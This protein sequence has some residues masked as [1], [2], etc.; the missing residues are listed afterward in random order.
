MAQHISPEDEIN[1]LRERVEMLEEAIV[2]ILSSTSAKSRS[3][4]EIKRLKTIRALQQPNP[5]L[6]PVPSPLKPPQD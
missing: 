5:Y 3:A 6:S 2:E 4:E 1:D